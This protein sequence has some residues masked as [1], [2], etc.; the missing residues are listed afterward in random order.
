MMQS[1]SS[2]A[3]WPNASLYDL[4]PLTSTMTTESGECLADRQGEAFAQD[5]FEAAAIAQLGQAV[6]RR[7]RRQAADG[8]AAPVP[9]RAIASRSVAAAAAS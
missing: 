7:H 4:K 6:G 1:T 3:A 5:G 9:A 8:P 2:P